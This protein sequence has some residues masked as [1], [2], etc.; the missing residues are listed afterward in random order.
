MRLPF[1][2]SLIAATLSAAEPVVTPGD[3]P[4]IPPTPPDKAAATCAVRPGFRIELMAAEP[5]IVDPVAMA[6][7]ENGRLY[8]VEMR[9][10]SERRDEK[11]GRVKLLEDTD[12][13]GRFDRATIFAEGLPWPT[14]ITCWDGGVF[15]LASPELLYFKDMD[16]D[17]KADVHQL[18]FT[19]FGNLAPKLN[20]QQLP[21]SLQWGPDQRIHGALG[22]NAGLVQNF[23]RFGSPKVELRGRD[24]S[25]DP[26]AMDL[27][28]ESGGGQFGMTFDD[29]GRKFVCSN[30]RHLM[31][32]MYED[33]IASLVTDYP[34]PA[35]A[36]DIAADGPQAEVFRRSPE[37][38]WRVLRTTWRV[39]GAVPGPIEG[40][41]RASG[42]FTGAT[43]VTVYRGDAW[44]AEF[45]GDVF[46]A[47]CGS[48]LIHR[49]K[50][51]GDFMRRGVRAA[52]EEKSEFVASTDN[53][54]RPVAFANAPDGNL[55]VAD[56][57][58]EVIEHPWSLPE[59]LK[60]HLDLN[61]GNDRGRI[62]RI[63]PENF[64]ARAAPQ[65]GK[66]TTTELA[67][68]LA[69]PNGWHRDTAARLLHQR[70]EKPIIPALIALAEKAVAP[71]SRL[72]ALHVLRGLGALDDATLAR[73]LRDQDADV[74]GGAVRLCASAEIIAPLA[75]DPAP[76]VRH[77]VAW[78]LVALAPSQK[79][80]PLIARAIEPLLHPAAANA[81]AE[82][83]AGNGHTF[84]ATRCAT[85]HRFAGE[86]S[87]VGPDLDA[88][89]L[90]GREKLLGNITEPSREIT[91]GFPLGVVTTKAGETIEGIVANESPGG[92]ILRMPG[93]AD[94][95]VK[96][97]D[98]AKIERPARS[99]M[100][101]AIAIGLTPQDMDDLLDFLSGGADILRGAQEIMGPL[102][103]TEKACALDPQIVEE[104]DCGNYVRRLLTYASEP[105]SRVPAYLLIPKMA[106]AGSRANAV[107]CLHPT[108][109]TLG[110]KT[111]VGL[112][113]DS[114]GGRASYASELAERGF[115][116]IA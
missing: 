22:G 86:G 81:I 1:L 64:T 79:I 14:G 65:L 91:A 80:A 20:V 61:S 101:D 41:G 93:G 68:T 103:G 9:D 94:R 102:P 51:S 115:V 21:N 54:F 112:G 48:N 71:A 18:V 40:G 27:R 16:G 7:D 43:G 52:G 110:H 95:A 105:G 34:L 38:P 74:R 57:Y 32:V 75:D 53:W 72:L 39:A 114:Y 24:F 70:Q 97:S 69:H 108:E 111:V 85:C 45:R 28:P 56:M 104:V 25:F 10:Y 29:T 37:E 26:R 73:S 107:L 63:V 46:V 8:V 78:T 84:F 89:R 67:A 2:V 12:G 76:R 92:V 99:L 83:P 23:A 90:A 5:L 116:T 113:G 59:S 35:P 109:N 77:E 88:A 58:R 49:K 19:G 33:R 15:V 6:F 13:D 4:L 31:Q 98:I 96:R 36:L 17:G 106:L 66:M 87:A 42:Y 55:W 82:L 11:L 100:P 60:S 44:P 62:Y 3:L 50:L 47:D 30:S